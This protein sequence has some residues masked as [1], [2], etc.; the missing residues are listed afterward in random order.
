MKKS[1][2][3]IALAAL[4]VALGALTA[5]LIF[6]P[7]NRLGEVIS[8]GEALVGGEFEATDQNGKRVTDKDFLGKYTLY[9][10]GYTYCPDVC[11]AELQVISAAL[12]QLPGAE[13]KFRVV[14]VS[15]DPERDTPQV[16][17]DYVAN[18]WPGTV[19][20]TGSA[21]DIRKIAGKFRVYY[22][23]AAGKEGVGKD[24][25]LMDHSS[26]VY[27]MGPDG[28]FIR[29]FPFGT[30]ADDMANELKKAVEG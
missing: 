19:G 20:L 6:M 11:P 2:I 17:K 25:Y 3:I 28:K 8:S 30:A 5:S 15:I 1:S 22:G 21:E 4:L 13:E 10:F 12:M 7:G 26:I 27:L 18:F 23:R 9:Y 24:D 29:H 16:M 14:F